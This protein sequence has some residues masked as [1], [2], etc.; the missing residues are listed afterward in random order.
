ML[1]TALDIAQATQGK[2]FGDPAASIQQI[3][4]DSRA[5]ENNQPAL[6]IALKGE[7]DGHSFAAKAVEAGATIL[8]VEQK[9]SDLPNSVTQI[10][11]E[12]CFLALQQL[13]QAARKRA[14]TAIRIA[15]TG[16]AGKTTTRNLIKFALVALNNLGAE[17]ETSKQLRIHAA[18]KSFNNHIGV[19]LTLAH[20]PPGTDIAIFE[21]GMNARGEIG[22]LAEMVQ[23]HIGIIS[24]IA[25]A[26]IGGP[27]LGTLVHIAH[28][29]SE[30]FDQM[31]TGKQA[32]FSTKT[33][34][35]EILQT[36]A[37]QAGLHI[38]EVSIGERNE[39]WIKAVSDQGPNEAICIPIKAPAPGDHWVQNIGL[40]LQ[41]VTL[42]TPINSQELTL[43]AQKMELFPLE[44]GRGG[45]S[46]IKKDDLAFTLIDESYNANPLS[47]QK[48][49]TAAIVQDPNAILALGDMLELGPEELKYHAQLAEYCFELTGDPK[50]YLCGHRS[51]AFFQRWRFLAQHDGRPEKVERA[52]WAPNSRA[53]ADKLI[54]DSLPNHSTI[55]VKGSNGANMNYIVEQLN[56]E[57]TQ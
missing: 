23:P 21:L 17:A 14:S 32:L 38:F 42:A 46:K 56:S 44:A 18:V 20:M 8:L 7:R 43:L 4:I 50:I 2:I 36:H 10:I 48:A 22:Q 57:N 26:H 1:W 25:P 37:E 15:V 11:V 49:I 27:G 54:A 45:I 28:A 53:L 3:H 47:M 31:K 6:F 55:M 51:Y 16:S 29:K 33:A 12:D 52:V 41:A 19:P 13:G 40:A 35:K 39:A 9:I 30:L 34:H 24:T 5:I